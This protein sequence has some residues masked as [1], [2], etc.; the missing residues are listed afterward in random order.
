[1]E[2]LKLFIVKDEYIEYLREHVSS[3]VFSNTEP[4]YKHSRK[5]LGIVLTVGD[6]KYYIPLSSPKKSDY[7]VAENGEKKIRKSIIPIMRMVD[8]DQEGK[9]ELLGTLKFS[10]MIPV[11]DD[12]MKM[13]KLDEEKDVKYK[14]LI[15]KEVRYINRHTAAVIK[16][17]KVI[18]KQKKD[19]LSIKY[20]ESTL[21]FEKLEK[22]YK[23][24]NEK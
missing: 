16:N 10:N 15:E 8:T 14:D 17:A 7:L 24:Y 13:Y 9:Q 21:D 6:Y 23:S 5:Y 3:H 2:D 4:N 18:Y 22:A 19:G 20:L 12:Q 11:P 1:M